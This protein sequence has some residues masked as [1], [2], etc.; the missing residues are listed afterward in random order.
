MD[1]DPPPRKASFP[2]G[3]KRIAAE[4]AFGTLEIVDPW[5][6]TLDTNSGDI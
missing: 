1:V 5:R 4:E 6:L 3:I 2:G